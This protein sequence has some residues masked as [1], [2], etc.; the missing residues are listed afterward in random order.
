MSRLKAVLYL[1]QFYAGRG[2]EDMAHSGLE[3]DNEA[4]GPGIGLQGI[5]KDEMKIVKTISEIGRAHV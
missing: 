5:W 4:K 3:I 1:N 2:G